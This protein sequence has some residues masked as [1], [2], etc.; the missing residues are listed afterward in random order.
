LLRWRSLPPR[1]RRQM[2]SRPKTAGF[3]F[4]RSARGGRKVAG[5][6]ARIHSRN[7]IM[8]TP[9]DLPSRNI[10]AR[11]VPND[12]RMETLPRHFG[13]HMMRVEDAV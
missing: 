10:E 5:N 9:T 8:D 2:R 11:K 3:A 6:P 1:A 13:R 4:D 12:E 7:A